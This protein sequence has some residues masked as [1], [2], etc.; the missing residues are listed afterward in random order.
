[1]LLGANMGP[2]TGV[3]FTVGSDGK[4]STSI[5]GTTVT[6]DGVLAPLIFVRNDQVNAIVPYEIGG[7]FSTNVV[8]TRDGQSSTVLQQRVVD[9]S[10][11]I[12]S[13]SQ[14]GNGQGAIL[15][16]NS[17]VN[18]PNN[19]AVKGTVVQIFATGEGALA[20]GA[21][22]GSFTSNFPPFPKPIANVAVSIGGAPAQIFY[23]GEAPTLVS[24]VLQVNAV[25]PQTVGSGPQTVLLT[26]GAN[27]NITQ[28]ITVQV[29]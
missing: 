9:T 8:V 12:F 3:I 7:R 27:Q 4:M 22:T 15:N 18:G 25:I 10:P 13:L 2:T 21:A 11:A 28:T 14:N 26:I 17:S 1:T 20:P 19:P 29:Q 23:A 24:G 5:S 6:F 16:A